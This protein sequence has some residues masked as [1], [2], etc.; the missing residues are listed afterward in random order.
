MRRG[1]LFRVGSLW[2]CSGL[3]V[4]AAVRDLRGS[5]GWNGWMR[6]LCWRGDIGSVGINICISCVL[7]YL[8]LFLSVVHIRDAMRF[9]TTVCIG[10]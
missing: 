4:L 10:N 2:V 9:R 1:Y 5:W 3:R 8:G 7:L 6:F